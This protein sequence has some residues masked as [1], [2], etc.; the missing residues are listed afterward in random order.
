LLPPAGVALLLLLSS[1]SFRLVFVVG[2]GLLILQASAGLDLPKMAY[3]AGTGVALLAA[4]FSDEPTE[5]TRSALR[6]LFGA[7]GLMIALLAASG[8][9]AYTAGTPMTSWLRD[10]APYLLLAGV[11]VLVLDSAEDPTARRLAPALFI[12]VG[13]LTLLSVLVEWIGR[14]DLADLPVDRILLP[15]GAPSFALQCYAVA[16]ILDG[17][18][19]DLRWG[20]LLV[21]LTLLDL[22]TGTR[23]TLLSTLSLLVIIA[24]YP[25]NLSRSLSRLILLFC[26][27]IGLGLAALPWVG[28]VVDLERLTARFETIP[29]V[30]SDPSSDQSYIQRAAQTEAAFSIFKDNPVL[31]SGP[32][33]PIPWSAPGMLNQ[34]EFTVDTPVSYLSKFGSVGLVVLVVCAYCAFQ[35]SQRL[36]SRE[37]SRPA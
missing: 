7:S 33:A 9:V 15:T 27:A 20:T 1:P 5:A 19:L 25:S 37:F 28:Q 13:V 32:G 10:A 3:F 26:L 2:G 12:T 22:L 21:A 30:L 14:R 4:F 36:R 23:G 6:P 24:I 34:R 31:G 8:A 17:Q 16:R 35:T 29:A 11:P 18:K